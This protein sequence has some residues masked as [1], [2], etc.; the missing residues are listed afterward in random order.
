MTDNAAVFLGRPRQEA[1]YIDESDDGDI[2]AVA[3]ADETG[4]FVGRIDIQAAGEELRLVSNNANGLSVKAGKAGDDVQGIVFQYLEYVAVVDA[5]FDDVEHIVRHAAVIGNDRIEAFIFTV[6]II[7]GIDDRR[8]FH[9]VA[10]Q[11]VEESLDFFNAVIFIFTGKVSDAGNGAV[12]HGTA[13]F[14]G[15][16]FFGRD[17]LDD[18]RAR[19]EHV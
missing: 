14:F 17:R 5:G 7:I 1:R 6:R 9:V 4:R 19:K 16:Y 10:G 3:E 15:R 8:F 18:G 12:R 11:E 13:Q 2:E